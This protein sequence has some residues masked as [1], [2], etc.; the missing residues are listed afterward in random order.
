MPKI[1][2][3]IMQISV[4]FIFYYIGKT[5][6][7][8]FSLFI[9]GS[10]IGMLLFFGLLTARWIRVEWVEDGIDLLIKDMPIFFV[11]VTV[12]VVQYLDFF[13]GKGSLMIP[14]IILST[15]LVILSGSL[16]TSLLV[17]KDGHTYE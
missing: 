9:P 3:I 16:I 1:L 2:K 10:I 15:F 6:Q 4:L 5:I 11:P 8:L 14:L 12:G 17:K 7:E 13:I